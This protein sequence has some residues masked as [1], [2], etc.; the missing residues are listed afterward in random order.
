MDNITVYSESLIGKYSNIKT[1]FLS[2]NTTSHLQSL[3][4]GITKNFKVKYRKKLMS[5][6]LA[7]ITD[8]WSVYEIVNKINV[9]QAINW[10]TSV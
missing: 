10:I 9:I 2:K 6:V 7:R 5:F 3:N 4:A 1:V 8:D